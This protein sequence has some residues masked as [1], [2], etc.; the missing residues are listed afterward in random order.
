MKA[1][2]VQVSQI[3]DLRG[4]LEREHA[5]IGVFLC[6]E[7]PT[8]PMLREAAEAGLYTSSDSSTYP[9]IQ[10][11]TIEQILSGAQP[12]YARPSRNATFKKAP[13]ARSKDE[14]L[15]LPLN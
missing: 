8:K 15:K 7:E 4:T 1:G 13:K 12:S 5:E 11:L 10:I 3:R 2:G 14:N 6:F 9:R